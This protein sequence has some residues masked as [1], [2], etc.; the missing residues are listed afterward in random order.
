MTFFNRIQTIRLDQSPF[1]R[2]WSMATLSIDTAAAGPAEHKI[3]IPYLSE[4]FA[5]SEYSEIRMRS[6]EN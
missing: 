6:S 5:E 2:R 1:D 3:R 4:D